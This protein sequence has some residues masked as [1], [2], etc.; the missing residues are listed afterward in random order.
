[1]ADPGAMQSRARGNTPGRNP[2][3]DRAEHPPRF[4]GNRRPILERMCACG[5][6]ETFKTT[7]PDKLYLNG[8]HKQRHYR[9]LRHAREHSP[10]PAGE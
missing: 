2:R 7:F 5:C 3:G 8:A 9:K 1:V 4:S 10:G 6:N